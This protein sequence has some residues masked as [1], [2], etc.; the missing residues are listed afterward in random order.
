M[1]EITEIQ[2]SKKIMGSYSSGFFAN[3]LIQGVL[4]FVLF[5]F[6]EVEIGLAS[7]MTGLGLV[8]YAIWDAFNDPLL[9][10]LSDR[11][12]RFTKK[13]GRRFPWIVVGFI[14]MLIAFILIFSPPNVNAQEQPWVIFGWLVFTLC[15]FDTCET[16][17][18]MNFYSLYPDKFRTNEE[19]R[20]L[21]R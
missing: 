20:K 17:F 7:W 2:H 4:I 10:Y 15:P 21:Y 8:C 12:F 14:P 11:P 9:G 18:T 5:Y 3:E 6:Y 13:W 19:R 16:F 1:N